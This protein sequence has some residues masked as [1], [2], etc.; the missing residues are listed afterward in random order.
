[1]N[2]SVAALVGR[3][4]QRLATLGDQYLVDSSMYPV[5]QVQSP[6]HSVVAPQIPVQAY[7]VYISLNA[8]LSDH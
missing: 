5:F 3:V 7:F 1:M 2:I 6:F 8:G 4:L